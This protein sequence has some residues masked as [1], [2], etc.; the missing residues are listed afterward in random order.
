MKLLDRLRH[1]SPSRTEQD[2]LRVAEVA[3]LLRVNEFD[4]F[5]LA[6]RRWHGRDARTKAL[7][8]LFAGYMFRQQI[9]PW[10]RQFCRDVLARAEAGALDPE[11]FGARSVPRREPMPDYPRRF[12]GLTMVAMMLL[13]LLVTWLWG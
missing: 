2:V 13:Y 12:I 10:V 9:P 3:R 8:R 7:E 11:E 6:Y 4:L 5:R 1:T